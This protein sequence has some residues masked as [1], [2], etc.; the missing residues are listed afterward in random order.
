[1]NTN[2]MEVTASAAAE[3]PREVLT[4]EQLEAKFLERIEAMPP[5]HRELYQLV[6]WCR[7]AQMCSTAIRIRAMLISMYGSQVKVDLADVQHFDRHTRA[8]LCAVIMH[9]GRSDSNLWD[10]C[11]RDA[12]KACGLFTW[13]AN[14]F[15][16]KS[17]PTS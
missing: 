15:P 10:Y 4:Q 6:W 16:K 2:T 7:G 14:G 3:A 12:V 5:G 13:W 8:L 17:R 1:M 11:I 9:L